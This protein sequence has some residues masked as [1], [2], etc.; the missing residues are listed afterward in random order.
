MF[1]LSFSGPNISKL[2]VRGSPAPDVVRAD[3]GDASNFPPPRRFDPDAAILYYENPE[4]AGKE[5]PQR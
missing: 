1:F 5:K 3:E 4:F 2:A